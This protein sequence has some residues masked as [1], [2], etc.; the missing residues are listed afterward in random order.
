MYI[1]SNK[2]VSQ[3]EA[4]GRNQFLSIQTGMTWTESQ[5]KFT[6][7]D[8]SGGTM[9][10]RYVEVKARKIKSND[11]STTYMQVDKYD[12]LMD[13]ANLTSNGRSYYFV[14]Y[15]D[16]KSYL[17][18]LKKIQNIELY[19]SQRLMNEVSLEGQTIKVMKDV[20]ELPLW[21]KLPGLTIYK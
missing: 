19:R 9:T 18:D 20:Y 11:F 14:R 5:D 12:N 15:L 21:R 6:V 1:I 2:G 13:L 16:G 3:Q 7:W 4:I 8:F 17:Y 10:H